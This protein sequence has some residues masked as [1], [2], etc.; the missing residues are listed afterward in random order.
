MPP[1]ARPRARLADAILAI[2][3]VVAVAR[4]VAIPADLDTLARV[5]TYLLMTS[6]AGWV[7]ARGGPALVALAL[8]FSAGG[9]VLLGIDGLFVAGMGSFAVAHVLYVSQFVRCGALARLRRRWWIAAGYLVVWSAL[10]VLLWPGLPADLRVPV[11]AY[12][13]LLTATAV[14]SASLDF[15]LGVG[16]GLFFFSDALI[17][18][19]LAELALPPMPGLWIMSTY[20][21]GQYLLASRAVGLGVSAAPR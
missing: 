10:I 11:A 17:A 7:L 20:I 5:S 15:W 18:F 16:G 6:L 14:T 13:L 3:I 1:S 21:V 4:L 19:E 12:S 9:D 8:L 2:F